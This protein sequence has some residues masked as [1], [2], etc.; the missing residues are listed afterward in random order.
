MTSRT[1]DEREQRRGLILGLTL[2]EVLL[3]LLFLLLLVLGGQIRHWHDLADAAQLRY[4]ELGQ[5]LEQ[6]K[7]LQE[8]L[9]LGGAVDITGVQRL[10]LR[11]Q[12]LQKAEQELSQLK[13]QSATLTQQSELFKS[14]GL[15][16]DDKLRTVAATV[17]RAS[18]I[19]PNDPPALLKRAV[20]VL[21]RL[22]PSTQ[23]EEVKPL[24]EMVSAAELGRKFATLEA[25]RDQIR[26]ERDNLMRGSGN[27]LTYPS[28]WT[29]AAGQTEYIFDVTFADS[30]LQVR[31]ASPARANDKAWALVGPFARETMINESVFIGATKKLF[32]WSKG[33]NCRFYTIVRDATGPTNKARYKRLQQMVQGNFYPFYPS[34]QRSAAG[35]PPKLDTAP[36]G[37]VPPPSIPDPILQPLH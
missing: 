9:M 19:D 28:C 25:D 26:R 21:D 13:I 30:G 24:S 7:P 3:L 8:A 16:S 20:D 37:A 31:H 32:E 35:A 23:P 4:E 14:L 27:G 29:T 10:V 2:A 22:G 18:E 1:A 5:S 11:F 36:A 34:P 6:L 33:Q 17:K 12:N 15:A